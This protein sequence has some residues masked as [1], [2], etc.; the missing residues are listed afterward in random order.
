LMNNLKMGRF[1]FVYK[2]L[3]LKVQFK[4]RKF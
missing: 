4:K 1:L 2:L 3:K